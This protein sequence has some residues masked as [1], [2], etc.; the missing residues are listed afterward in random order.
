MRPLR[1]YADTSVF[2]GVF[3]EEFATPSRVFFQQV[4][5]GRFHLLLSALVRYE[6][7]DAPVH[8]RRFFNE[9]AQSSEVHD[10]PKKA[11]LLRDSYL[12]AGIVGPSSLADALHVA[13][14][15]VLKCKLIV[16]WNFKHIVH[17]EK[18]PRYNKVNGR[19][20][21]SEIAIHSP[22]EVIGYAQEEL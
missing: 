1:V 3:D 6:L 11:V 13:H 18:I 20:G 8:V 15:T 10:T 5:E 2:G 12:R 9:V 16:S 14:A 17:F 7:D 19:E 21:Y 22:Q 4:R